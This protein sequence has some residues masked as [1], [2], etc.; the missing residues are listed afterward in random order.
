MV[1]AKNM[2]SPE[3]ITF[4]IKGIRGIHMLKTFEQHMK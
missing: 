4:Y 1:E 2:M 3:N